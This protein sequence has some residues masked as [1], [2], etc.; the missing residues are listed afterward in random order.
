MHLDEL[1]RLPDDILSIIF[2]S[3]SP[4]QKLF[5]NKEYYGRFNYL[6]DQIIGTRYESYVRDTVRHNCAFTF[7][8]MIDRNFYKWLNS[9]N[10]HY[11]QS[12]Y[13]NFICF[14]IEYSR[15]NNAHKCSKLL[16][17]QLQLSG[18]KKNWYKNNRI[19]DNKWIK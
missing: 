5:L 17:V 9:N 13:N 2:E 10:Y 7:N 19:K 6:V 15:E 14:L 11:K 18:L 4:R 3:I 16:N 1:S 12:I 8:Y